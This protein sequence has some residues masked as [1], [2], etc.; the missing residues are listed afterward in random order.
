MGQRLNIEIH[1][2]EMCLANA[3]YH[4]SGYTQDALELTK[5]IIYYYPEC[6]V[7]TGYQGACELLQYTG[8]RFS[9]DEFVRCGVKKALADMIGAGANRDNGLIA[10]TKEGIEE[11]R[12]WEEA[13]VEIDIIAETIDFRVFWRYDNNF[14]WGNPKNVNVPFNNHC[15]SFYHFS[16]FKSYFDD[17]DQKVYTFNNDELPMVAIY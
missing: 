13:R 6:R 11:T 14:D 16:T 7:N 9:S 4:W 2:G 5:K 1:E 15:V 17:V 8:A 3:Y 10:I 12:Y